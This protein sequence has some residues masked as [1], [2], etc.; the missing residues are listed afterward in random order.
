MVDIN[1]IPDES[2]ELFSRLLEHLSPGAER[3]WQVYFFDE[4]EYI[5]ATFPSGDI[6]TKGGWIGDRDITVNNLSPPED[7]P[8][9]ILDSMPDSITFKGTHV[10]PTLEQAEDIKID[11]E[12]FREG[13]DIFVI[14]VPV[15]VDST[16]LKAISHM[17]EE[18]TKKLHSAFIFEQ[19]YLD[20]KALLNAL[21]KELGRHRGQLIRKVLSNIDW[22]A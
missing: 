2:D 11:V 6:I 17:T 5:L 13:D 16:K 12:G 8:E 14:V 18:K 1:D 21:I 15:F 7:I 9:D 19:V 20:K 10:I 22:S 4:Q 3:F